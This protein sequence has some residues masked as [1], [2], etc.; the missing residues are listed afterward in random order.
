MQ[1]MLL[2]SSDCHA[3]LKTEQ[4]RDYLEAEYHSELDSFIADDV[5]WRKTLRAQRPDAP[6]TRNMAQDADR[7]KLFATDLASRLPALD[8]DGFAGEI[9]F[10]DASAGNRM[11]FSA[12]TM[13][14]VSTY[15][16]ESYTAAM[17]GYNRWL[18]ENVAPDRQIGLGQI[19]MFDPD[20]AATQVKGLRD[21]GLR[22]V[23]A[24]WDGMDPT[25]PKLYD[26]RL[27][28]M[29]AACAGDG[30]VVNFHTGSGIPTVLKR[31]AKSDAMI[32]SFE[33]MF[34]ARRA[35]WHLIFG[36]V[37]ERHP[38]LKIGIVEAFSD[39]VPRT[40]AFMDWMWEQQ[41]G[42]DIC[43][44]R[45]TEYFARQCFISAHAM[46]LHEHTQRNEFPPGVLTYATDFPHTGSTWGV[47][48]E[49]LQATMGAA[50]TTEAEARAILGEN[51][52]SIYDLDLTALAPIVERIGPMPEDIL[53]TTTDPAD[54]K[55][56]DYNKAK[57]F[58]PETM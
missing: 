26:E 11:P 18:A 45:P 35:L 51:I 6:S 1:R 47:S 34:W 55:M 54:S 17:R 24:Q 5:E 57:A 3:G 33:K 50:G 58:R 15:P 19:P 44:L 29:W 32:F 38:T 40:L 25:H 10:P 14:G 49:F 43:P 4:Y 56:T 13:G 16:F 48:I 37:L 28:P 7:R 30:L 20:Y 53:S 42:G 36:G 39:W 21:M 12:A 8:D 22:G 41:Q 27:D 52:A 2:F 46:S 31:E 23:V 9:L